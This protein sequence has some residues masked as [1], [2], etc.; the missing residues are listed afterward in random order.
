MNTQTPFNLPLGQFAQPAMETKAMVI[1]GQ[2]LVDAFAECSLEQCE[3]M[4]AMLDQGKYESF[5]RMMF[6]V[7]RD[8]SEST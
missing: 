2:N 4:A 6:K 7:M 1:N 3:K 8:W 5:G